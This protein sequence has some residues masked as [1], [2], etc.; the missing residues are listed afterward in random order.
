M[1]WLYRPGVVDASASHVGLLHRGGA[2]TARSRP[3]RGLEGLTNAVVW[4]L[5]QWGFRSRTRAP[6]GKHHLLWLLKQPEAA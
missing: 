3:E 2:R 4:L 6:R 5:P 1:L